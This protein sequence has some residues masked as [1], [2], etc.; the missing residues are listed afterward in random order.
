MTALLDW[1]R[2]WLG[3]G[4]L[5]RRLLAALVAVALGYAAGRLRVD[6]P[7]PPTFF[8]ALLVVLVTFGYWLAQR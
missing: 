7:A 5:L 2:A 4:M 8:G 1:I 3:D 6:A